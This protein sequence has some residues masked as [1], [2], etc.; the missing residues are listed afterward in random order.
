MFQ[1][2]A[3][4]KHPKKVV[5]RLFPSFLTRLTKDGAP[6][7]PELQTELL[8]DITFCLVSNPQCLTVWQTLY[9][10]HLMQSRYLWWDMSQLYSSSHAVVVLSC[11]IYFTFI[12]EHLIYRK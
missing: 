5:D 7:N 9:P 6:P 3:F 11:F 4:G 10:Q 2:L 12:A 8:E 1:K